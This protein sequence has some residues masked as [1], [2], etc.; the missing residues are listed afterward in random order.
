MFLKY[1]FSESP[2]FVK[3]NRMPFFQNNEGDIDA[4]GKIFRNMLVKKSHN[5]YTDPFL[6]KMAARFG[7]FENPGSFFKSAIIY[8]FL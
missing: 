6:D 2:N 7:N 8:D 5:F 1:F 4:P 3:N